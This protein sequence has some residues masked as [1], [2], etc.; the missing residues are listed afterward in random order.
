MFIV[1]FFI[2]PPLAGVTNV[3]AWP[4]YPSWFVG[5]FGASQTPP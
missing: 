3:G 1:I 2:S 4:N 5:A